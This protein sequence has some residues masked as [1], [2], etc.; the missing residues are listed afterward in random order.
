M[1]DPV[2]LSEA[3]LFLRVSHEDEDAL[4]AT[5]I[6]A[7]KDRLETALGIELTE[8]S[9][10]PLRLALLDLIARAYGVRGEGEVSLE[11][12]EPWIAPYRQ[13]RL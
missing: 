10:A 1:A 6:D 7:A 2:S 8:A 9:P 3:K 11:G 12:L 13:V 5:L 4:I